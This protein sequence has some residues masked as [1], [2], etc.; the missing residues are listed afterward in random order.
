MFVF[1]GIMP[2]RLDNT[3]IMIINV[4]Q[5]WVRDD[6]ICISDFKEGNKQK[7]QASYYFGH[8]ICFYGC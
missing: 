3:K 1:W 7:R 4:F 6:N 8:M 5:F 2:D